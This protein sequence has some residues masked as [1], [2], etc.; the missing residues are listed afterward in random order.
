MSHF[1]SKREADNQ[2][3]MQ[4]ASANENV[5]RAVAEA[6]DFLQSIFEDPADIFGIR[7]TLHEAL[8]NAV[9]HGNK[10]DVTQMVMARITLDRETMEIEVEDQGPGF[11]YRALPSESGPELLTQGRG[12]LLLHAYCDQVSYN[13][14]GNKISFTKRISK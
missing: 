3:F 11:D 1:E 5:D 10:N 13:D 2:L 4:F 7:L 12:I 8:T 6:V 9:L 14:S